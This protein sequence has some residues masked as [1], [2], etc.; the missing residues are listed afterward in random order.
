MSRRRCGGRDLG[1][2]LGDARSTRPRS[3]CRRRHGEAGKTA[4]ITFTARDAFSATVKVTVT[5]TDAAGA[6]AGT[7]ACGWVKQGKPATCA[8]KVGPRAYTLSFAAV[9][10]AG[11]TNS[12]PSV[13]RLTVR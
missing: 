3:A 4:K 10:R 13:T 9:D 5:V 8:W 1:G 6:V 12:A 7:V 11:N 2:R